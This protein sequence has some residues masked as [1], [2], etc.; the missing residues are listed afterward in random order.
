MGAL[1]RLGLLQVWIGSRYHQAQTWKFWGMDPGNSGVCY[2]FG[3]LQ[4]CYYLRSLP[5]LHM[6]LG[7]G[8]GIISKVWT[9]FKCYQVESGFRY[10]EFYLSFYSSFY[11]FFFFFNYRLSELVWLDLALFQQYPDSMFLC[12]DL[13]FVPENYPFMSR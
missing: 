8:P 3:L 2:R 5:C 4:V 10:L 13:T 11:L 1:S 7:M 12:T 9:L 6:G